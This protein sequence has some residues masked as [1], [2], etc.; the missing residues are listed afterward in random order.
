MARLFKLHQDPKYYLAPKGFKP[1]TKAAAP[2]PAPKASAKPKT[3]PQKKVPPRG[4]PKHSQLAQNRDLTL[5]VSS[6]V[7]LTLM[8]ENV[9]PPVPL[10]L[11][12]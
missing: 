12:L 5:P 8:K 3:A 7:L 2:K 11:V 10:P 4:V 6:V 9:L 1:P